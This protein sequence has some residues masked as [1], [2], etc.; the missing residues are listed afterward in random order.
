MQQV[1]HH[2]GRYYTIGHPR[3]LFQ[4]LS[5]FFHLGMRMKSMIDPRP[6]EVLVMGRLNHPYTYRGHNYLLHKSILHF[7]YICLV[8]GD[9]THFH[10]EF[11][12]QPVLV[13][14]YRDHDH[15]WVPIHWPIQS[16]RALDYPCHQQA[17][18]LVEYMCSILNLLPTLSGSKCKRSEF[19]AVLY[20]MY[21]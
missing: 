12:Q 15:A 17:S 21:I 18:K 2:E 1:G 6:I 14:N 11:E 10:H 19:K 8:V 9:S 7:S 3:T 4:K 5:S 13:S 20:L 16:L